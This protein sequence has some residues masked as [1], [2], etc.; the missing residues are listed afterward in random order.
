MSTLAK[1]GITVRNMSFEFEDKPISRYWFNDD[2][3]STHLL[4]GMSATFPDGERFFIHS[5]RTYRDRITD[6]VLQKEVSAFIGQEAMHAKEHE[7]FNA[8][9]KRHNVDVSVIENSA[10]Y[11]I[12]KMKLEKAP[13]VQLAIT[14]ALEHFTAILAEQL[15]SK[16]QQVASMDASM[17]KLWVWHAIEE[18]E[19]KAVAFDVYRQLVGDEDLR[20]RVML[21]VTGLFI[22]RTTYYTLK[23]MQQDG[24]LLKPNVWQKG[25]K[26]LLGKG[27]LLRDLGK[28]YMDYYRKDFHPWQSDTRALL[29]EWKAKYEL[30]DLGNVST[31]SAPEALESTP[32]KS[33]KARKPRAPKG[34]AALAAV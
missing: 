23:L 19:H 15:L 32:K 12:E 33:V 21:I 27:G 5:L 30:S 24:L 28:S 2:P 29:D 4:N 1:S 26:N 6:A 7:A 8:Y 17:Q 3:L 31:L 13:E 14:C 20:R 18:N 22:G 34:G 25:I 16:P 9:L 11:H 10:R